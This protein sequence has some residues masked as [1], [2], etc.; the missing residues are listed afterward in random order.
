MKNSII[1]GLLLA[2]GASG[3]ALAADINEQFEV[4]GEVRYNYMSKRSSV[5]EGESYETGLRSRVE[6]KYKPTEKLAIGIMGENEHDFRT[7]RGAN[8]HDIRLKQA[9][10]EAELGKVNL[11]LGRIGV[12]VADGKVLDDDLSRMDS[13]L[14]GYE[15][16]DKVTL[17]CFAAQALDGREDEF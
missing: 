16:K 14:V 7:G 17:E 13:V 3:S 9:Y 8:H 10:I 4:N 11:T 15:V 1:L 5:N 12:G 2:L 6:L